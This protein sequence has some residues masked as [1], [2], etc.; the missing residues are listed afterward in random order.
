MA[1]SFQK[2]KHALKT[3]DAHKSTKYHRECQLV[4]DNFIQTFSGSAPS[5]VD[6]LDQG[7]Q[8]QIRENRREL[9]LRRFFFVHGR[10]WFSVV[11]GTVILWTSTPSP[12]K[13]RKI[14]ERYIGCGLNVVIQL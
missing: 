1:K 6:Q 8:N 14:A 7:R 11:I 12:Q 4:A 10:V 2:W 3:F 13:T 5:A 9:Q